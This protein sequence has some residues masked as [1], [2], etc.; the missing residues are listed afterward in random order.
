MDQKK[1]DI[2]IL[3][4]DDH[5]I[6]RDGIIALIAEEKN[7]H[8]DFEARSGKEA[9]EILSFNPNI[10]LV[11]TD[12]EMPV[13]DGAELVRNLKQN[14]PSIKAIALTMHGDRG[15]ASSMLRAGASGYLLKSCSREQLIEAI[16]T[17]MDGGEYLDPTLSPKLQQAN[18]PE[19]STVTLPTQL[20][21]RE[22][23]IL[24]LIAQG[25]SNTEIGNQL[26][27]S[28]RTVDTHRTN[29]MRKL[30]VRNIAGLIR[31][32]FKHQLVD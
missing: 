3:V 28:A 15:V 30:D 18:P 23:E 29:L 2:H 16:H 1:E 27:I 6:V 12:V 11:L 4:V 22:L 10:Q 7:F 19:Q 32:A 20:T 31:F 24:K 21:P 9:L 17:V 8:V 26:F 25:H 14:K 13:M 5:Q